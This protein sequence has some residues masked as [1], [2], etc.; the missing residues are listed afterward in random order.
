MIITMNKL[1]DEDV[2]YIFSLYSRNDISKN[3]DD[4]VWLADFVS[5]ILGSRK[6]ILS[7]LC[8]FL[9]KNNLEL[10]NTN[11]SQNY[12]EKSIRLPPSEG[13]LSKLSEK[14][15][16]DVLT[17]STRIL[18]NSFSQRDLEVIFPYSKCEFL[19]HLYFTSKIPENEE[20]VLIT[21]LQ[22]YIGKFVS[23]ILENT[24]YNYLVF[25]RQREE[26]VQYVLK[27]EY[28]EK[29]GT[30]FLI[31][32]ERNDHTD[33]RPLHTLL[34]LE[35]EGLLKIHS[36]Q[37]SSPSY[38]L[39]PREFETYHYCAQ[40]SLSDTFI[41]EIAS[42]RN[43]SGR[44]VDAVTLLAFDDDEAQ[45]KVGDKLCQLPPFKNEHFFCRAIFEYPKNEPVDWSVIYGK[46]TGND[47]NKQSD[48]NTT[49]SEKRSVY[50]TMNALN[51]RVMEV[52]NTDDKL[53]IWSQRTVTRLH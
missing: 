2:L 35:M 27:K 40:V 39:P 4:P 37:I 51:K 28:T 19:E 8:R 53:F 41:E 20:K 23:G 49:T 13:D 42:S 9:R 52:A 43:G 5:S 3:L 10:H 11:L 34:A 26:F 12:F 47:Q 33:F 38:G 16:A 21:A 46:M 18:C 50:D 36:L 25:E 30:T 1:L 44:T 22:E 14:E 15:R 17:S 24:D 45:L 7:D 29:Y 32:F 31:G 6:G 48:G